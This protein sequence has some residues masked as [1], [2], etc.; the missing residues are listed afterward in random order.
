MA[1]IQ[2]N[3]RTLAPGYR[4]DTQ[5]TRAHPAAAPV[6]RAVSDGLGW[7]P[8]LSSVGSLGLLVVAFANTRAI[9]GDVH[10]E[11]LLW[12]GL[13]LIFA[14]LATRQLA[15]DISRTE[16]IGLVITLL[17]LLYCVKL[18][19][20]P[21][22]FLYG[23]EFMH[24]HNLNQILE[25]HRLFSENSVLPVSALYPG[26]EVLTAAFA[27]LSGLSAYYAGVVVI[28]MARL[29]LG[30][31]LFLFFEEVGRSARVAGVATVLYMCHSNFLFWSAQYSYESLS[32]PLIVTVLYVVL[33]R[34]RATEQIQFASYTLI[35]LL[36][37]AT[38]IV[39]HHLSSYFLVAFLGA[40]W[41]IA[42]FR[43]H[44]W[45]A[46][47]ITAL[48]GWYDRTLVVRGLWP[49]FAEP[50]SIVAQRTSKQPTNADSPLGLALFTL[51]LALLWLFFVAHTTIDYL[52]PVF[53][54]ALLSIMQA[55]AREE[56][57]SRELFRSTEGQIAPLWERVFGIGS[58]LLC[59][60]GLP[61][62]LFQVC[63]RRIGHPLVLMLALAAVG[64]FGM[65][66][67][68]FT[69]AA[70]ETGNRAQAYLF[71]G[72]SFAVAL[73][74]VEVWL[75]RYVTR[76]GYYLIAS[77]VMVVFMGGIIAG[78]TPKLRL[79]Q[80]FLVSIGEQTIPPQGFAV[81]EW[82]RSH[83][84]PDDVFAADEANGRLL[85]AFGGQYVL[86]GRNADIKDVL[87][88]PELTTPHIRKLQDREVRYLLVD[89]R[90][91]SQ[92]NMAGYFYE[93]TNGRDITP[94]K[95]LAPEVYS[96]FDKEADVDRILDSGNIFLY[97]LQAWLD[98]HTIADKTTVK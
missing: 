61:F 15:F 13:F 36:G 14:P 88:V 71:S 95:L 22:F 43:L 55:I 77:Y 6:R 10:A 29:L 18:L 68:R 64:Y 97:D 65:L 12:L 72:L 44:L 63:R 80:P 5:P 78:W 87:V 58:V 86:A 21:Y 4:P 17:L 40:W 35:A 47:L 92:D 16:R 93:R 67:L 26:L 91:A 53:H 9:S 33:C 31:A 60:L 7:L 69:P 20:N 24:V 70:W 50:S 75:P 2:T 56:G 27:E 73:A 81:A 25:N 84:R 11:A 57:V 48:I 30:L 83:I 41:F 66:A 51:T 32:L 34:E 23:D 79:A 49:I 74:I 38:I 94:E 8:L 90:R 85:L 46:Q 96:K 1:V 45:G 62:G 82:V 42:Y 39:T 28:G 89:R 19:Q 37:I 3:D 98:T 52:A 54:K 59:L 76:Y